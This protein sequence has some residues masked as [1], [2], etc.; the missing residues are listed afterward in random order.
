MI[1][2]L[3]RREAYV[4]YEEVL[5]R[6]IHVSGHASQEDEADY[7]PGTAEVLPFQSWRVPSVEIARGK[8][9]G[10]LHSSVGKVI[11]IESGDILEFDEHN[12]RKAGKSR[13]PCLHRFRIANGRG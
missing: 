11:L 5:R 13:G 8:W 7:Q 2:H 10:A 6:P 1:D 4:I 12:A 3:F 9:P